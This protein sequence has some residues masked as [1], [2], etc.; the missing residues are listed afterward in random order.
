MKLAACIVPYYTGIGRP[1]TKGNM[2][3]VILKD[4]NDHLKSVKALRKDQDI[5]FMKCRWDTVALCCFEAA[6][7]FMNVYI[8]TWNCPLVCIVCEEFILILKNLLY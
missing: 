1:L 8:S 6:L 5:K 3:Y 7:T 4:Y 2:E